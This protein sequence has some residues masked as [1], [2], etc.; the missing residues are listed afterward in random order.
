MLIT[1]VKPAVRTPN[2]YNVFVDKQYSFSL[3]ES[4]LVSEKL[5]SGLEINDQD[6]AR[7]QKLSEFGKRYSRLVDLCLRRPHSIKELRDYGKRKKWDDDEISNLL[8]KLQKSHLAGDE[9]FAR[10][11]VNSR[12]ASKKHGPKLIALE[13]TQKGVDREIINLVMQELTSYDSAVT[14]NLASLSLK[15]QI[16]ENLRLLISKKRPKYSDDRKLIAYLMRRGFSYDE[17]R[18]SLIDDT[19]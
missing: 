12:L 11:W 13:L 19:A 9:D 3:N 16:Q 2:R 10:F 8:E 7:L 6:L 14:H 1:A 5:H 18:E 15:K 17:I 4:Q